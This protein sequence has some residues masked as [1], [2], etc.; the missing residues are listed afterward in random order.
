MLFDFNAEGF[1]VKQ[2][3]VNVKRGRTLIFINEY[4]FSAD[5]SMD[6]LASE[7]YSSQMD[8]KLANLYQDF[9]EHVG[10]SSVYFTGEGTEASAD[11]E[12]YYTTTDS[13]GFSTGIIK[14]NNGSRVK[15]VEIVPSRGK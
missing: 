1:F 10:D 14:G 2:L 3:S 13:Y 15:V 9:S 12:L 5:F 4:D 7:S 11:N 8:R 6:N